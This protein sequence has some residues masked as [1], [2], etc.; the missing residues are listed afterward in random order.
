[1]G[2]TRTTQPKTRSM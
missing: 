1:M 2:K